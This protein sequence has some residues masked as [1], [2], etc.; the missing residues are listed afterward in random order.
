[1]VDHAQLIQIL[2]AGTL[3]VGMHKTR[4][5]ILNGSVSRVVLAMDTEPEYQMMIVR[6]CA[7]HSVPILKAHSSKELG[8]LAK[9]DISAGCI[10]VLK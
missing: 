6:L 9:I 10:G 5:S 4:R 3:V 2:N 8:S 1:M 7:E